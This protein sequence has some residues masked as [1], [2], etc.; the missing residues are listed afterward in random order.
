MLTL[1]DLDRALIHA[2][3]ID[4]RAPFT[5][6]AAVLGTSTQT[7][8]RRYGRLRADAGLRVVSLADPHSARRQQWLVRLTAAT[9]TAHDIAHALAKR[10]DTSWVRLTSGGTEIVAIIQTTPG[11]ADSHALLLRDIPRTSSI[12]AVSA[13]YL[14]HTY[15]GGP[16][17]WHGRV[18][19]LTPEQQQ[20][21]APTPPNAR[22]AKPRAPHPD[23]HPDDHPG[24]HPDDRPNDR[25]ND[26]PAGRPDNHPDS[27]VPL[28]NADRRLLA[29]LARDGRVSYADLAK[30]TGWTA[31]TVTRRVEQLR[32]R[33]ALFFD[34]EIDDALLGVTT[35]AILWM[36]V[37]PAH[38]D[39]VATALAG[40]PE[41]AVVASTTGRT[42]L[43]ANVLCPDPEAL[44]HYLTRRLAMDAITSIETAPI[45][46]TLKAAGPI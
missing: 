5:R 12:T 25:P 40:H 20:K 37:A 43:M 3:H 13:H 31:S 9:G 30:V 32:R 27:P 1:D 10:A 45:L 41:L 18:D 2:L 26:R 46:R 8:V 6:I 16:T 17:A 38:L 34:V 15:L 21:L 28:T 19:A 11:E 44:H 39:E 24:S 23:N 42:N 14:L 33:G 4:A 36:S 29:A 22:S 35:S 7:V